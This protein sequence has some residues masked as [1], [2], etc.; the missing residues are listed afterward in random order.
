M[1]HARLEKKTP[2]IA[3]WCRLAFRVNVL[4]G[5]KLTGHFVF[6]VYLAGDPNQPRPCG[7]AP[8]RRPRLRGGIREQAFRSAVYR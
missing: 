6:E 8:Y 3:A 1:G 7:F 5:S 2:G 4:F